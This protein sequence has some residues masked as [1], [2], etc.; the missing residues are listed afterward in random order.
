MMSNWIRCS[1]RLPECDDWD[2]AAVIVSEGRN[3][4]IAYYNRHDC[5]FL[6]EPFGES[7]GNKVTH[8]QPLPEPPKEGE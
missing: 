2:H 7:V 6:H 8:W 5:K 3:S 1:E 4:F